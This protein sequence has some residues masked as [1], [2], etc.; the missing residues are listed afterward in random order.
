M[1]DRNGAAAVRTAAA[2]YSP[3]AP[4]HSRFRGANIPPFSHP[5]LYSLNPSHE[6]AELR[7]PTTDKTAAPKAATF[8]DHT[9]VN[10]TIIS[11]RLQRLGDKALLLEV[12][13]EYL[14]GMR[15]AGEHT[16][17]TLP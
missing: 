9:M 15:E 17:G 8:L 5:P 11:T 10:G 14:S 13:R 6:E 16:G 4:S 1:K 3:S 12:G 2:S 7:R